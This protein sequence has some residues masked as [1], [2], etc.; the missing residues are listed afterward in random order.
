MTTITIKNGQNL[1]RT[2][3]DSIADLQ[4]YLLLLSTQNEIELTKEHKAILDERIQDLK[5]NPDNF[6]SFKQFKTSLNRKNV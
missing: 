1:S 6:L 4:D 3:F 5:E 2:Q